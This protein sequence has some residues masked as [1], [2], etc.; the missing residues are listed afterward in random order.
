MSATTSVP[1]ITP[2]RR[3][4]LRS[5]ARGF[6]PG[7][8]SK[9]NDA[10]ADQLLEFLH[11]PG[12][13]YRTRPIPLDG[14]WETYT[15]AL[16]FEATPAVPAR[17][18]GPLVLRIYPTAGE[19]PQ[20]RHEFTVQS[21]MYGRGFPTARPLLLVEDVE[22]FGGP[23]ELMERLS[24][25]ALLE[26]LKW[27]P[28]R[29]WDLPG[30]MAELQTRLHQLSPAGFPDV[31]G[32][33]LD[34]TLDEIRARIVAYRLEGLRPGFDWLVANRPR[35]TGEPRPLHLDWHPLNL[36]YSGHS[37]SALDWTEADV[38]DRHADVATSLMMLL[39]LP[40]P[41]R[42]WQRP[43]IPVA[44]GIFARR[45]LRAYRRRLALDRTRLTYY[46]AWC[47]L[48]RLARYGRW[49][50]AGPGAAG[51]KQSALRNVGP[52]SCEMLCSYFARHTGVSVQLECEGW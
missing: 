45:Y 17:L 26:V 4:G 15:Y 23:F 20:A 31:S 28:W 1:V 33:L 27:Q 44:R 29:L 22:P 3:F 25:Q 14:G 10:V 11:T 39:C 9:R 5:T 21:F 41:L 2:S 48:R 30:K 46:S 18:Q 13:R 50:S 43:F 40:A 47:S 49:L 16:E 12:L 37:L 32:E 52:A 38:G 24:G 7:A 19:G 8:E 51:C 35:R 34:R 42:R 6:S 36:V